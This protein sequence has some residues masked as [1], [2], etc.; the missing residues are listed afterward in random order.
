M[1]LIS[2][3]SERARSV[4]GREVITLTPIILY[5]IYPAYCLLYVRVK[6]LRLVSRE[7]VLR[8]RSVTV[9]ESM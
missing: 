4:E 3:M 7:E 2:N 6:R 5:F 8:V 9:D 1:Y